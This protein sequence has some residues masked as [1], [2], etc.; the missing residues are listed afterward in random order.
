MLPQMTH[1]SSELVLVLPYPQD[2]EK[3]DAKHLLMHAQPGFCKGPCTQSR[4]CSPQG[5]KQQVQ[6][7]PDSQHKHEVILCLPQTISRNLGRVG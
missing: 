3:Q 7:W 4:C 5:C 6:V 2:L 1:S